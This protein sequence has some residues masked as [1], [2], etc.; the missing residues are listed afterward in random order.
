MKLISHAYILETNLF[1]LRLGEDIAGVN[2]VWVAHGFRDSS[3]SK[4]QRNQ[5]TR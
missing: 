5:P 2:K 3:M 1:H 4:V